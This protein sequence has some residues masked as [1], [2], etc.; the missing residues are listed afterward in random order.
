[1]SVFILFDHIMDSNDDPAIADQTSELFSS[2][3]QKKKRGI[4][5]SIVKY[6]NIII[7]CW[8][9]LI[10]KKKKEMC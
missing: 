9:L 5:M 8:V 6:K 10:V 2:P 1:M 3:V 4:V 7:S